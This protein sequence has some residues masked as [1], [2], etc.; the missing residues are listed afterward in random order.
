MRYLLT[1][2]VKAGKSHRA[3]QIARAEFPLNRIFI[4]TA[5]IFDSEM[6]ERIA[7]H[8]AE[9]KGP[10]G[11]DDFI[12]IE[13]PIELDKAVTDA[14]ARFPGEEKPGII[15]DCIPMWVNNMLYHDR[16]ADLYKILEKTITALPE[17]TV[18]VTNEIGWGN[19]PYD[20]LSRRYNRL[21]AEVN[22]RLAAAVDR[23]ELLVTGIP[24][25]IK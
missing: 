15:I 9:R 10:D 25:R 5:E 7:K 19:I 22:I 3:L 14:L 16:E 20:E 11:S 13:E 8:R 18:I 21:V 12:T 24:V 4:A 17:D 6:E 2:A 23:V 1:G